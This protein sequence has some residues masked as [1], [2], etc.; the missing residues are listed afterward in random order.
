MKYFLYYLIAINLIT[1][2]AFG[3]DKRKAEKGAWRT[4]ESTLLGLAAIGGSVGALLGM[5]AFRHKTKH[6]KFTTGV[7]AI[8]ILQAAL[9][10]W[11]FFF[12]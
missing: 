7:P 3:I 1:F 5:N 11:W 2:F 6:K 4:K 10:V 9:M 8:L 12:K